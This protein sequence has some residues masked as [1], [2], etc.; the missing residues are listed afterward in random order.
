MSRKNRLALYDKKGGNLCVLVDTL[1]KIPFSSI[2]VSRIFYSAGG[3]LKNGFR[4]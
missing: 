3:W 1:L 4:F 2:S